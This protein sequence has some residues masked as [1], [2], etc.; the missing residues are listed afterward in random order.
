MIQIV[1]CIDCQL[2]DRNISDF[3]ENIITIIYFKDD[4]KAQRCFKAHKLHNNNIKNAL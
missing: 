4:K 2:R 3:I 1:S